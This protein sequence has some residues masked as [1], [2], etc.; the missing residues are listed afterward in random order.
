MRRLV[1]PAVGLFLLALLVGGSF[2]AGEPAPKAEPA[3][4]AA[5]FSLKDTADKPVS[6]GDFKDKKAVVVVFMG[7]ECPVNNAYMPRLAELAK[8]YTDK[9]VQFL[10][11]NANAQDSLAGLAGYA[12]THKLPFPLL[13]DADHALADRLGAER[14]PEAFVLDQRRTVRYRGRI[15]DQHSVGARTA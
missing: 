10:G 2:R 11:V 1:P 3:K 5:D 4:K 14:T 15:D 6:L 13:K 12:R 8:A 9:G 7:T